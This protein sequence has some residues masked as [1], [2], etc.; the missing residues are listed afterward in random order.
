MRYSDN[1]SAMQNVKMLLYCSGSIPTLMRRVTHLKLFSP[2][3]LPGDKRDAVPHH[4]TGDDV[5]AP[6]GRLPPHH[7]PRRHPQPGQLGNHPPVHEAASG[8]A[9]LLHRGA[10]LLRPLPLHLYLPAH[11]VV[12]PGG[13]L[14]TRGEHRVPL[15][16]RL[17]ETGVASCF[18]KLMFM[19]AY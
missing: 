15:Q 3:L 11:P 8:P 19:L 13:T 7:H 10:G 2:L 5:Q 6:A 9:Q 1:R 17:S 4:P 18:R 12:H 14:A 16:V